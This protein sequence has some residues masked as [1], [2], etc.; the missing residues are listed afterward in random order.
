MSKENEPG[1]LTVKRNRGGTNTMLG[2]MYRDTPR[3]NPTPP[4][5]EK[6]IKKYTDDRVKQGL[7]YADERLRNT[8]RK[9][10]PLSEKALI[11]YKSECKTFLSTEHPAKK[12]HL[13]IC[14]YNYEKSLSMER[15]L[16]GTNSLEVQ[17]LQNKLLSLRQVE[18][19]ARYGDYLGI[20]GTRMRKTA[21]Q[22]KIPSYELVAD[23]QRFWS[24]ILRDVE[25][26][27]QKWAVFGVDKS[28]T[29]DDVK[30]SLLLHET[31][32][33]CGLGFEHTIDCMRQYAVRNEL[34]HKDVKAKVARG[35]VNELANML[36][37]DLRDLHAVMPAEMR[38]LED[39]YRA[40][41]EQFIKFYFKE[42]PN[43][44]DP[45][46]WRANDFLYDNARRHAQ[47]L[48]P[49]PIES[50]ETQAGESK[51]K[52]KEKKDKDKGKD[53]GKGNS[54]PKTKQHEDLPEQEVEGQELDVIEN[55]FAALAN[56]EMQELSSKTKGMKWSSE[57][58]SSPSESSPS[59]GKGKRLSSSEHPDTPAA[60]RIHLD[61][62][63]EMEEA[64]KRLRSL[65]KLFLKEY[66]NLNK[67]VESHEA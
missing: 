40:L 1:D 26:E 61:R 44:N 54:E 42:L 27:A 17:R 28:V 39:M 12:D 10:S 48:K 4:S 22:N 24:H 66:G 52:T 45:Q 47:S 59:K 51:T 23:D 46:T 19:F 62:W 36:S 49:N 9:V 35:A 58:T 34:F 32:D 43:V 41:L 57:S 37:N 56:V 33:V 5:P 64:R 11:Y 14:L 2:S 3:E 25:A 20:L 8:K 63:Q 18:F 29:R 30:T 21:R 50:G 31:C 16:L 15:K 13:A 67:P 65:E 55:A 6:D 7:A 38:P 60:Q 53:K